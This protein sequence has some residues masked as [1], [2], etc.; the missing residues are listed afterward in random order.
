MAAHSNSLAVTKLPAV[1]GYFFP[2]CVPEPVDDLQSGPEPS[3]MI[4]SGHESGNKLISSHESDD[5]L[6]GE[7][8]ATESDSKNKSYSA[9]ESG[10]NISLENETDGQLTSSATLSRRGQSGSSEYC[11]KTA[12]VDADKAK[13]PSGEQRLHFCGLQSL[14]GPQPKDG[15]VK[16][17]TNATPGCTF[18]QTFPPS[19]P[20]AHN[21]RFDLEMTLH[22]EHMHDNRKRSRKRSGDEDDNP[23]TTPIPNLDEIPAK[24]DRTISPP[25]NAAR[26]SAHDMG[27][28]RRYRTAFS[29]EQLN[30][31]ESEFSAENYVSRQRRCDLA[32]EL[33]LPEATIKVWFQNRRMKDKRMKQSFPWPILDTALGPLLV[34][35]SNP[36]PAHPLSQ[37]ALHA[38]PGARLPLYPLHSSL[39]YPFPQVPYIRAPLSPTMPP[40][41]I[42]RCTSQQIPLSQPALNF[43]S[44]LGPDSQTPNFYA[45]R[46]LHPQMMSTDMQA[47]ETVL[48]LHGDGSCL[49][50]SRPKSLEEKNDLSSSS[51]DKI[52]TTK[53]TNLFRPFNQ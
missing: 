9:P 17:P 43:N 46:P 26:S 37:M 34:G 47:V 22:R 31:L 36:Y 18:K 20:H 7:K 21:E 6:S 38:I 12:G 14:D 35:L 25:E 45:D 42:N 23:E 53:R 1:G 48:T 44:L 33:G 3:D 41:T 16:E 4:Y 30:A 24:K 13:P 39:Y 27:D 29:K 32:K 11:F 40:N 28:I 19:Y 8:L 51:A 2:S 5:K 49:N 15:A 52:I 50:D 10:N